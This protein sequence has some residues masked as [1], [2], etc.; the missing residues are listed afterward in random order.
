MPL[1]LFTCVMAALVPL[2]GA[3]GDPQ[4]RTALGRLSL[5]M[6]SEGTEPPSNFLDRV[7]D[8]GVKE[9]EMNEMEDVSLENTYWRLDRLNGAAFPKDAGFQEPHLM[10][11]AENQNSY[12]A[13]LGCNRNA[14]AK[15][16]R[17]ENFQ[18][19]RETV[20]MAVV[21]GS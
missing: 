7:V 11:Q 8:D 20:G 9:R 17:I 1:C 13:M 6:I 21:W 10:F 15:A 12:S 16:L 19:C 2:S 4:D 5:Q 18:Q 3:D 14:T